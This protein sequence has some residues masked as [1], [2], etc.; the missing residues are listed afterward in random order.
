[1]RT[2]RKS[3][4]VIL[5][6]SFLF[7]PSKFRIDIFVE[8]SRILNRNFEPIIL[9]T[10]HKELQKMAEGR[11][12]KLQRQAAFALKFAQHCRQIPAE[13]GREESHDDVIVRVASEIKCCVATN[14][15]ALKKKLRKLNVPVI[16]MRQKTHLA[17]DG[18]I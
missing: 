10:T 9:S 11:P 13:K 14:D 8:L 12:T 7:I 4:K 1:M 17:V 16:Y 6:S 2:P 3:L 5:D 15:K 18:A